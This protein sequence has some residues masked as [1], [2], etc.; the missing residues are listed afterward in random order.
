MSTRDSGANRGTSGNGYGGATAGGGRAPGRARGEG[1]GDRGRERVGACG[2]GANRET[3]GESGGSTGGTGASAGATGAQSP[4]CVVV[5]PPASASSLPTSVPASV[6]SPALPVGAS[7]GGARKRSGAPARNLATE[8][9]RPSLSGVPDAVTTPATSRQRRSPPTTP[10]G[11]PPRSSPPVAATTPTTSTQRRS[12]PPTPRSPA[13]ARSR[14]TPPTVSAPPPGGRYMRR[15]DSREQLRRRSPPTTPRRPVPARS[16]LLSP[17][18]PAPPP[19]TPTYRT[20]PAAQNGRRSPSRTTH[21]GPHEDISG[22]QQPR[23]GNPGSQASPHHQPRPPTN[24][25]YVRVHGIP[26][27]APPV[28]VLED[29]R[30]CYDVPLPPRTVVLWG[31]GNLCVLLLPHPADACRVLAADLSFS[32]CYR[33][34]SFDPSKAQMSGEIRQ[35]WI[36]TIRRVRGTSRVF[37]RI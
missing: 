27:R 14:L 15:G 36:R 2:D 32:S 26:R 30:S 11:P 31:P 28:S 6:A 13:P 1:E 37:H 20:G 33:L 34:E 21:N 16:H 23:L 9:P 18:M 22:H 8:S 10:R 5:P 29:L 17:V 24:G 12:P 35:R 7:G 3:S 4:A 25:C 19:R